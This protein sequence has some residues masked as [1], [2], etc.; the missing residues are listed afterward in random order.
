MWNSPGMLNAFTNLLYA[1]TVLAAVYAAVLWVVQHP[2]FALREVRVSGELNHV[3]RR[4]IE[5]IVRDQL[6]GNFFTFDLQATCSALER[7]PWV[8]RAVARRHWPD[9]VEVALEEHIAFARWGV[10]QLV[11]VSGQVFRANYEAPLPEFRGPAGTAPMLLMQFHAFKRLLGPTGR[12]PVQIELSERLAW[13]VTLDDAITLELGREQMEERLARFAA[14]YADVSQELKHAGHI[15]L[16]YG[17]GFAVRIAT[18]KR[19]EG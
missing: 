19:S 14:A 7:L 10:D 18:V 3:T 11:D 17:K 5:Q 2:M 16:R 1:S 9:R 15:D 13:R 12:A 8:K 4:D 6:N